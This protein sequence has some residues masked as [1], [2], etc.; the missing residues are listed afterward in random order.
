MYIFL[1]SGWSAGWGDGGPRERAAGGGAVR[2]GSA[3][4]HHGRSADDPG[5]QADAAARHDDA[6]AGRQHGQY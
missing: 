5:A 3:A 4:A 1:N 2:D 6:A